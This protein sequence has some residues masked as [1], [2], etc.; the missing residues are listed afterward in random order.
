MPSS[1]ANEDQLPCG[2]AITA[3]LAG[4]P[5][6]DESMMLTPQQVTTTY[7]SSFLEFLPPDATLAQCQGRTQSPELEGRE[8]G[9]DDVRDVSRYKSKDTREPNSQ[10]VTKTPPPY[11]QQ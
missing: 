1:Y 9:S 2:T 3:T 10:R 11:S 6:V 5:M 4:M 7:R 8:R